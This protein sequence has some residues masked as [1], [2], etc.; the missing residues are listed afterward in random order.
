MKISNKFFAFLIVAFIIWLGTT[1]N[2]SDNP[3]LMPV[4]IERK[5]SDSTQNNF[6]KH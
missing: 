4:K 1:D 2:L 5:V 3:D 6:I